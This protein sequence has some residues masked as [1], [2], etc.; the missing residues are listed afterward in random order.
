M[1]EYPL[2]WK[3]VLKHKAK[4]LG[5]ALLCFALGSAAL[6]LG[7]I[8][9][10][11]LIGKPL[12]VV[13]PV[14]VDL[15]EDAS[16]LCFA[17]EVLH[18]DTPQDASRVRVLVQASPQAQSA[19]VRIVSSTLID[20]PV[21]IV[22]LHTGCGQKTTRRYVLLA[23]F[24]GVVETLSVPVVD[25]VSAPA[26][27]E[28]GAAGPNAPSEP[29][30]TALAAPIPDA[31]PAAIV[32]P[33]GSSKRA[34][35]PNTVA[36]QAVVKASAVS[37]V[38][39]A[40]NKKAKAGPIPGQ[41][42]LKLEPTELLPGRAVSPESL[43]SAPA[44]PSA[45]ILLNLQK[46]QALEADLKAL[47]VSTAKTEANLVDLRAR[48]QKAET[49]RF[50]ESVVFGLIALVLA[51]L[52][53]LAWLWQRQRRH[54]SG[55]N[56]WWNGAPMTPTPK[57]LED[58]L[59]ASPTAAKGLNRAFSPDKS[60]KAAINAEHLKAPESS[61]EVDVSMIEMGD[62]TFDDLLP[63]E[64]P[65][66]ASHQHARSHVLDTAAVLE[67]QHQVQALV[68]LG[69]TEHAVEILK[70]KI[71]EDEESNPYWYLDLLGLYHALKQKIEFQQLRQE[72]NRL[73]SGRVPEFSSFQD[74]GSS[75]EA[76]PDILYDITSVWPTPAVGP[77]IEACIFKDSHGAKSPSFDLAAFRDLMLLQA[78][79][80]SPSVAAQPALA[81]SNLATDSARA[82]ELDLDLSDLEPAGVQAN[83]MSTE[84]AQ[85]PLPTLDAPTGEESLDDAQPAE[86]DNLIDFDF[87]E[88]PEPLPAI[89]HK[90]K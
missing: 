48:L 64:L 21:V 40:T 33:T 16:A 74:E 86:I 19:N 85:A 7:R 11:A 17:A 15:G 14:Q 73:F 69:Q 6:T 12:D 72:F 67:L 84:H 27:V 70:R 53:A 61:S 47:R 1:R 68:S 41:P 34:A 2:L 58:E 54:Q 66:P 5:V 77:T 75:L 78:V 30:I 36:K 63:A 46:M 88:M 18:A 59:P 56:D 82:N 60:S 13:V 83:P 76:Y 26:P 9:G 39:E 43:A 3:A 79:A 31:R 44:A 45:D 62:S 81:P 80:Q 55:N 49:E 37:S 51:A 42:R 90:P 28:V 24:P 57:P 32:K 22:Y 50:P 71:S 65:P 89:D 10:A 20:E 35:R 52:A 87:S 29:D 23:D 25:L 4:I 8:R 38:K